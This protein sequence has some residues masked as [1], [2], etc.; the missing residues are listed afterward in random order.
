MWSKAGSQRKDKKEGR[1]YR[2]VVNRSGGIQTFCILYILDLGLDTLVESNS[3][4]IVVLGDFRS[5]FL[6][7]NM[8]S[9]RSQLNQQIFWRIARCKFDLIFTSQPN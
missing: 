7:L 3:H 5:I 1:S 4:L 9:I 8:G 2:E 6:L